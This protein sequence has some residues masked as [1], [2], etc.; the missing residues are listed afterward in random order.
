MMVEFKRQVNVGMRATG[1]V[2]YIG[3]NK[4]RK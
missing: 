4:P 2:A 3:Y 1:N